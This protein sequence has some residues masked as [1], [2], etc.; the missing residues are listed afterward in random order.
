[1]SNSPEKR[2]KEAGLPPGTLIYTGEEKKE[3]PTITILD[4]DEKQYQEKKVEKVEEC[5]P[6]KEKPTVTWINIDGIHKVEIIEKIGKNF[7]LHPLLLEDILNTQQRQKIEDFENHVFA[8]LKMFYYE[9][10][11]KEIEKEQIS[12]ILGENYVISFQEKEGDVFDPIRDRIRGGKGKIR[13][14]GS[15]YLAYALIDAIVDN[16]YIILEN[17]GEEIEDLEEKV[18]VNPT[19]RTL[20]NIQNLK[21]ELISLRKSFWTLREAIRRLE[22]GEVSL[23]KKKNLIYFRDIYDHTIQAVDTLEAQREMLSGLLDIYLSSISNRMN[24]VMKVLTI[25]ATIFIPLTFIAGVYGMNFE[26]MPELEVSWAY[27]TIL[28]VMFM[29]VIGMVIYFRRKEWI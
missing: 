2:H 29:V 6:F 26:F 16:Y 3:E 21:R 25:I 22:R 7:D 8:V 28:I 14:E 17:I 10:S 11:G 15:D 4:Y 27:P 23:I 9:E 24:E 13:K 20:Q 1:M 18:L 12:L 19:T 5:F